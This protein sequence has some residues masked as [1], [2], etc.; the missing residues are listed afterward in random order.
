VADLSLGH[1]H[2]YYDYTVN[3]GDFDIQIDI[4][5]YTE[6][7]SRWGHLTQ[8]IISDS[9]GYGAASFDHACDIKLEIDNYTLYVRSIIWKSNV[10]V[11][12]TVAYPAGTPTALRITRVGNYISAY[13]YY[14]GS[15]NI[16][17]NSVDLESYA[18][19]L[20]IVNLHVTNGWENHGGQ[21]DFDNLVFTHG[22]PS[23][24]TTTT[25]TTTVTTT[26]S[27]ILTTTTTIIP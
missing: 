10:A 19:T 24:T 18:S 1:A 21:T 7:D 3:S 17:S 9:P 13:Y 15:W 6:D 8:F 23:P 22:C 25:T 5:A 20:E 26:T 27:S 4:A 16:L 12:N 14:S 11:D 2:V